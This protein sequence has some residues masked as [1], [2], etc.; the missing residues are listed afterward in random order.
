MTDLSKALRERLAADDGIEGP[1]VVKRHDG[2]RRHAQVAARRRQRQRD[3]DGL[4]SGRR[5]RHAVHL[6]AG[7]LRA[8]LR[9][10]LD[11]QAGVQPQSHDGA[12]SSASSGTRTA[13]CSRTAS[14]RR[15][16]TQGRAPITNVVMMGMGEPL[17]NFDNVVPRAQAVPR[18]QRV[19]PVAPARDAVDVRPRAADRPAR[20]TNVRSRSPCQPACARRRAARPDRA[21]QPQASDR[22]TAGRLQPLSAERAARFRH[23]RVRDARRRQR[24]PTRM[25]TRSRESRATCPAS[26]T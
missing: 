15:G 1:Q 21:D 6:V 4:H 25:R 7:R 19:R 5:S 16:S 20:A 22:R 14:L 8:R 13:R 9:V 11:R 12:R 17:A 3:R 18:R 24:P 2:E 10:L 26:S 23:V